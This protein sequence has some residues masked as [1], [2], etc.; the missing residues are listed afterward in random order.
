MEARVALKPL[1]Y[2]LAK[3]GPWTR[4][5]RVKGTDAM[6]E[7]VMWLA[8]QGK[9]ENIDFEILIENIEHRN[10]KKVS[11][12]VTTTRPSGRKATIARAVQS[13]EP[14]MFFNEASLASYV[15]LTWG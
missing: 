7:A 12:S 3:H 2:M 10:T 11:V 5:V 4:H 1:F 14:I 9:V 13:V 8:Q 6:N 15:K